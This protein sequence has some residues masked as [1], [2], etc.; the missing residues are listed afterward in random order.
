[1]Q[2]EKQKKQIILDKKTA[3]LKLANF[4]AYQERSQQEV[5]EKLLKMG[6]SADDT[7]DVIAFLIA[8][9]FLNE[10]RFAIAYAGGKFRVKHW[11]N[12]K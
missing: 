5:R 7:E 1:M 2:V 11:G 12:S 6:I 10:E 8:E 9:N 4:C 3:Q